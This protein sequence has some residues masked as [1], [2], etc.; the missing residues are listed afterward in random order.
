MSPVSFAEPKEY[1]QCQDVKLV[2]QPLI[3]L[4]DFDF[5]HWFTSL[6]ETNRIDDTLMDIETCA[7][8][9]S[10]PSSKQDDFVGMGSTQSLDR[11]AMPQ[12]NNCLANEWSDYLAPLYRSVT[13]S[14]GP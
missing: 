11:A 5:D 9:P 2:D 14:L 1:L 3:A 7:L 12:R 10:V 8:L 4:E 13:P 6:D